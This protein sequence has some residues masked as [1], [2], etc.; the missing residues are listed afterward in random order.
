MKKE[1]KGWVLFINLIGVLCMAYF[2]YLFLSHDTAV[3]NPDAMIP[4]Q[5]WERGGMALTIGFF[6]MLIANA[7]WFIV[8]KGSKIARRL[9]C[10]IPSALCFFLAA[11]FWTISLLG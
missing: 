10:F 6:P 11:S 3:V 8:L 9:F 7:L 4:F 5:T 2:A 1:V